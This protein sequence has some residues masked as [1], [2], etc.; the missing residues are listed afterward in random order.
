[1][2]TFCWHGTD[3]VCVDTMLALPIQD[4]RDVL[5]PVTATAICDSDLHLLDGYM[6]TMHAGDSSATNSW[7]KALR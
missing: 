7:E 4:P 5:V 3:D 2:K 6:P 1:M